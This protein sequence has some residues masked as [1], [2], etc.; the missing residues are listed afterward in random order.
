MNHYPLWKNILILVVLALGIF[1]ALPNI[2][3]RSPVVQT[4]ALAEQAV[5]ENLLAD[6]TSKLKAASINDFTVAVEDETVITK[7]VT[8]DDQFKG[9]EIIDDLNGY[10]SALNLK[11]NVP[12]WLSNAGGKAMSLGL[13]LRGGVYFLMEVDMKEA[14]ANKTN[15]IRGDAIGILS[16]AKIS[17]TSLKWDKT[18][19][20]LV[21]KFKSAELAQKAYDELR[22][23]IT[24]MN[25]KQRTIDGMQA[26]VG[27]IRAKAID[28]IKS[29]ALEQNITTIR[30]RVNEYGVAEPIVQ[31]QGADRIIVQLP[32]VQDSTA[33]K[34]TLGSVATLEYR[35][36]NMTRGYVAGQSVPLGYKVFYKEDGSPILL[37]KRTIVTGDQL[38]DATAGTDQQTGGPQVSVVLNN[39]GGKRMLDFTR[40]NV[41]NN[42]AV[43]YKDRE[44]VGKDP[45]TGRNIYKPREVVI[46][47]ATIIGAFSNRF[48][49]TGL[50]SS[51]F[52]SKL[53]LQLRSGS[54]AAPVDIV[55]EKTIGPSLGKDNI[56]KGFLSVV[57]GFVLVL[58][59]ML[60]YYKIFGVVAN[61]ALAFN[62]VLIVAVLSLFGATLTLPGIAGIVLTV[63]MAVDANVL[64]FERIKEELSLGN[65]AQGSIKSGYDKALSTIADAN[66][67]TFIAAVVLFA[68]GTGPIKGFAVTLS[69]G[70]LTSMFTAIMVS[71][72]IVNKIYGGNPKLKKLSI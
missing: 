51:K 71:R 28:E 60:I 27:T 53:A 12:D 24:E 11:P 10:K 61:I 58:I 68:F 19:D 3:G 13:D 69:I 4:S 36:V 6:I 43:V 31:R 21:V 46:N 66:I 16:K 45:E 8:L 47:D 9:K 1:Y 33:I 55:H 7:F 63:G 40:D 38:I 41:D 70:I 34:E 2:Y 65:T 15:Q 48:A 32:G 23:Q 67:T 35:A 20:R 14:L 56:D 5:D 25:F 52:A 30:S 26:V 49:T 72:A 44:L 22:S 50:K 42:M 57:V 54:L 29:K 64:I 59:F 39:I 37:S 18:K 62:V 17:K